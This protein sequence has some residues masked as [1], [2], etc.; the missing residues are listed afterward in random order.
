[1]ITREW[2]FGDDSYDEL[3]ERLRAQDPDEEDR[4]YYPVEDSKPPHY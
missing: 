3:E 4:A 2:N 1:M